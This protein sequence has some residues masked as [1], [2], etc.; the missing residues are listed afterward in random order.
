M[1]VPLIIPKAMPIDYVNDYFIGHD[2]DEITIGISPNIKYAINYANISLSL[3]S[4][5]NI[6]YL[7]LV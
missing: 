5:D 4:D 2:N 6:D 7:Y 3:D 1:I